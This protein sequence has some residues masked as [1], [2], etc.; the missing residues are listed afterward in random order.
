MTLNLQ[1]A[2]PTQRVDEGDVVA[3]TQGEALNV[4]MV[5]RTQTEIVEEKD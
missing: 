4:E 2:D 1:G 5:V 3:P